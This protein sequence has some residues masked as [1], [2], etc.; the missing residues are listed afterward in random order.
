MDDTSKYKNR[1]DTPEFAAM[2]MAEF[3]FTYRM[4]YG[5]RQQSF[6]TSEWDHMSA[7]G[8]SHIQLIFIFPIWWRSCCVWESHVQA[9]HI[10]DA[11]DL[12][13]LV[14]KVVAP[15]QVLFAMIYRPPDY[16]TNPLMPNL[17]HL[18]DSLLHVIVEKHQRFLWHCNIQYTFLKLE[19]WK[20]HEHRL[21]DIKVNTGDH[22][23][24]KVFWLEECNAYM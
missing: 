15:V 16:N 13:F 3:A 23:L 1:P 5:R 8:M 11:T 12:E 24:A 19:T 9:H 18:L 6:T 4:G 7:T 17:C 20:K 22:K 14:L 10:Q 2:C 21:L